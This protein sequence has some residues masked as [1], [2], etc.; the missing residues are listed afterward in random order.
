MMEEK[1]PDLASSGAEESFF[2]ES[3]FFFVA[4]SSSSFLAW[5]VVVGELP[6]LVSPVPP[7]SSCPE[8]CGGA[9]YCWS[10]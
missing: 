8:L 4:S 6:S 10:Q 3:V 7:V 1:K 5:P 2:F 9:A